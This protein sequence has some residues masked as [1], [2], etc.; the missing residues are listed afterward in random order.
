MSTRR[1]LDVSE[2]PDVALDH[3]SP[4]WWGNTLLLVIETVMLAL[5]I[6]AYFYLRLQFE[7][8]PPPLVSQLPPEAHPV[9]VLKLPLFGLLLLTVSALPMIL[10]DWA[11]LR[12]RSRP[13]VIGLSVTILLALGV[14]VSRWFEFH[15][16]KF[17]W[18]ENAYG[19]ITWLILGMHFTHLIVATCEALIMLAWVLTHGLDDKHARDIR[20]TAVYWYWVVGTWLILFAVVWFTPRLSP[21]VH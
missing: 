20:T 2:I 15:A 7:Q 13:V 4:I 19:S 18:D 14:I 12:R 21:V 3:R 1:V 6:A 9:P 5:L 10:V 17:R 11:A 16:L 8:W